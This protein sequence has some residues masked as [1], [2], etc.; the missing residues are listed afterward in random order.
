[1]IGKLSSYSE[2]SSLTCK[3]LGYFIYFSAIVLELKLAEFIEDMEPR[4]KASAT[5]FFHLLYILGL[6]L[7]VKRS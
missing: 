6:K 1:M 7:I 3:S 4:K 2:V 5:S